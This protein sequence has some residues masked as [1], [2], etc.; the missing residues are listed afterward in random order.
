MKNTTIGLALAIIAGLSLLAPV[1]LAYADRG[2]R[3]YN[4]YIGAG[5]VCDLAPDACPV[6]STAEKVPEDGLYESLHG[7]RV[8]NPK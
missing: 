4:Y 6:I 1:S 8:R 3:T 2:S 5:P 7:E